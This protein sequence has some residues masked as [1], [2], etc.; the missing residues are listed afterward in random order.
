MCDFG[1]VCA[2]PIKRELATPFQLVGAV[3][4]NLNQSCEQ[5]RHSK[6]IRVG[7]DGG[8]IPS[9]PEI[10]MEMNNAA[11]PYPVFPLPPWRACFP[12]KDPTVKNAMLYNSGVILCIMFYYV[13]LNFFF[14][15]CMRHILSIF[16]NF[17][18]L[19]TWTEFF[20]IIANLLCSVLISKWY[21]LGHSW[22]WLLLNDEPA[23][24]LF[25][26]WGMS[27]LVTGI[28]GNFE[29]RLFL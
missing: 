21:L 8:W 19:L 18:S 11:S 26:F 10:C 12:V 16:L 25:I 7:V 5:T 4:M 28:W 24:I 9:G 29:Q 14:N 20:F 22:H 17:G 27:C 2:A 3:K 6:Q 23:R 1:Q 13:L 15:E